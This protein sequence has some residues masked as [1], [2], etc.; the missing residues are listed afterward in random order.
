MKGKAGGARCPRPPLPTHLPEGASAT[1][2]TALRKRHCVP[3]SR[4]LCGMCC[5]T[6]GSRLAG[7]VGTSART[8]GQGLQG[9]G[10]ACH[11]RLLAMCLVVSHA[12]EGGRQALHTLRAG[13]R[14]AP[15]H[16]PLSQPHLDQRAD[17]RGLHIQ[18][19]LAGLPLAL[20]RLG[21]GGG[22]GR[23]QAVHQQLE[24]GVREG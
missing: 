1:A 16:H 9:G 10:V 8:C 21:H 12:Q 7:A 20:A 22:G 19:L 23:Q 17:Y 11:Q 14:P 15:L 2:N 5:A 24:A 3:L 18:L 4:S 13:A 6:S